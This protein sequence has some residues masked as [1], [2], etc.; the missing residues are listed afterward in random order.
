[1]TESIEVDA[2][3]IG[4][5]IAACRPRWIWRT[6]DCRS[7][8][9]KSRRASARNDDL[10]MQVFPTLDCA[11]CITTPRM[12][13]VSHHPRIRTFTYSI[14]TR[15]AGRAGGSWLQYASAS[16]CRR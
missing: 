2:L 9:S 8:W 4:S 12:A 1:M 5:G 11:S 3:V 13:S 10:P 6:W 14:V 15:S 16:L 7:R